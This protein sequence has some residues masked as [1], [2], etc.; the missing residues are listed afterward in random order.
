MNNYSIATAMVTTM[1]TAMVIIII[2]VINTDSHHSEC[3]VIRGIIVIIIWRIIGNI[4][5]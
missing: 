1:I 5:R 3:H 2:M 4:N